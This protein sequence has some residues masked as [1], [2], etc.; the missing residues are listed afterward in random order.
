MLSGQPSVLPNFNYQQSMI[1]KVH[2]FY[3]IRHNINK[4]NV[5]EIQQSSQHL[6][7][8]KLTNKHAAAIDKQ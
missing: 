5:V 8:N 6:C 4:Q 2:M 3:L 7:H 1:E